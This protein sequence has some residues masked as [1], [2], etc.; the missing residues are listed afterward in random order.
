MSRRYAYSIVDVFTDSVF[1]GNPLAVIHDAQ[2]LSGSD[3]QRIAREFN[4]SE[5]AFVLP[6][7]PTSNTD[8]SVRIFTPNKE[9]PF[10]GHPNIGTAWALSDLGLLGDIAPRK[11]VRFAEAAGDVE[12]ALHSASDAGVSAELRAPQPLTVGA[13]LAAD[14]VAAALGLPVR[15]LA[16]DAH[17]PVEASVGLPFMFVALRDADALSA[18]AIDAS[19]LATHHAAGHNPDLYCYVREGQRV[20]AR[21]F[22]PYDGVVEDPATGSAGCAVTALLHQRDAQVTGECEWH[23]TQGVQMG[24]ASHLR[25]RTCK[26]DSVVDAIYIGG[27]AALFSRGEL[28]I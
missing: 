10:A 22:A 17:L 20:A 15:A 19:A 13:P 3:M 21:M 7:D 11:T 18:A 27:T 26:T 12:L 4:F 5:S 8:F 24:R 16:T 1:S 14:G 28:Y 9:V 23:I 25:A 2:G 6:G